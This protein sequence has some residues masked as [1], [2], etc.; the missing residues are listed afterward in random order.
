[1][2]KK[3]RLI[4]LSVS[5]LIV[6]ILL[7]AFFFRYRSSGDVLFCAVSS[8][9]NGTH[10]IQA[11][12]V[13]ARQIRLSKRSASGVIFSPSG[14]YVA[15]TCWEKNGSQARLYDTHHPR[16]PALKL[17]F[18]ATALLPLDDGSLLTIEN[19]R[20]SRTTK[21]GTALLAENIRYLGAISGDGSAIY[22]FRP[23]QD[24]LDLCRVDLSDGS[25]TTLLENVEETS[26]QVVQGED[27]Q[28]IIIC[29]QP[30]ICEV[31]AYDLVHDELAAADAASGDEAAQA[32]NELREELKT[33]VYSD[34]VYTVYRIV[35]E[36]QE[37]LASSV[38]ETFYC[39]PLTGMVVHRLGR[40]SQE[41]VDILSLDEPYVPSISFWYCTVGD[42]R[43]ALA[44][45][46]GVLPNEPQF[47]DDGTLAIWK[48][49]ILYLWQMENGA[50]QE[51]EVI[52]VVPDFCLLRREDG[53]MGAYYKTFSGKLYCRDAQGEHLLSE[54]VQSVHLPCRVLPD[55]T[56]QLIGDMIYVIKYASYHGLR[57]DK[58]P[59]V[60]MHT[61]APRP[62]D[63]TLFLVKDGVETVVANIS[64][65]T[66]RPLAALTDGSLLADSCPWYIV[67][68]DR[69]DRLRLRY[70]MN[71]HNLTAFPLTEL[72]T[73]Q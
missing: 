11:R 9:N 14:R 34:I 21:K 41:K 59:P 10:L 42:T 27:G 53:T 55:G 38:R 2:K 28:D 62:A 54:G 16:R 30:E 29:A 15:F 49:S 52:E 7:G 64:N 20:L 22:C 45:L 57:R 72:V 48:D 69:T 31:T 8:P 18:H 13:G 60:T 73:L 24:R 4:L 1:M 12:E 67:G 66:L 37:I 6:L 36:K 39:D 32:R 46:K 33:Q 19:D 3:P 23:V 63:T 65:N 35:G 47:F 51:P 71:Q 25:L 61:F 17:D 68:P 26:L 58:L 40:L 56:K 44:E 50:L 43:T 5:L 70:N